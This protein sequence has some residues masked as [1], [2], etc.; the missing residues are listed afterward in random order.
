MEYKSNVLP[1]RQTNECPR[2]S[3]TGGWL[4]DDTR[5]V[6]RSGTSR[7]APSLCPAAEDLYG[8]RIVRGT[9]LFLARSK[10]KFSFAEVRKREEKEEGLEER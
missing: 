5:R 3:N 6:E 9:K 10:V 1:N 8:E 2:I 4:N 7:V